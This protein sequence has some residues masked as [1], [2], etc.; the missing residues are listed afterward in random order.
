SRANRIRPLFPAPLRARR[1]ASAS[2]PA[3]C[4]SPLPLHPPPENPPCSLVTLIVGDDVRSLKPSPPAVPANRRP[5]ATR[6]ATQSLSSAPNRSPEAGHTSRAP[7]GSPRHSPPPLP[8][9][10]LA[11]PSPSHR[12]P[13]TPPA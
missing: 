5:A 3:R 10:P 2:I 11:S 1:C 12:P 8:A 6:V 13:S 7:S 4:S 9:S